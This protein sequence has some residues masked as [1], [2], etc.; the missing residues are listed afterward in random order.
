LA[1]A[2]RRTA[3]IAFTV[4]MPARADC[5]HTVNGEIM[6]RPI[7]WTDERTRVV[8]CAIDASLLENPHK[9]LT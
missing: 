8:M 1:R 6:A 2:G 5:S 9:S 4:A 7:S 3:G